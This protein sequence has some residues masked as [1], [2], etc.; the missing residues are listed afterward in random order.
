MRPWEALDPLRPQQKLSLNNSLWESLYLTVLL[1]SVTCH[2]TLT[3]LLLPAAQ[4]L[5]HP[6]TSTFTSTFWQSMTH[7]AKSY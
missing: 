4:R 2:L 6:F 5:S 7:A 1:A 3:Y